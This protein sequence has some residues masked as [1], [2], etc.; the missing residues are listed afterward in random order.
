MFY[1]RKINFNNWQD[2]EKIES[3]PGEAITCCLNCKNNEWSVY[4]LIDKEISKEFKHIIIKIFFDMYQGCQNGINIFFISDEYIK[5]NNLEIKEDSIFEDVQHLNIK[6]VDYIKLNDMANYILDNID[7]NYVFTLEKI[8]EF[9][10][11]EIYFTKKYLNYK[12]R[13]KGILNVFRRH[14]KEQQYIELNDLLK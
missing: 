10:C 11:D 7:I 6:E 9:I 2:K 4:P 12:E 13:K 1:L 14:H 8:W 3:L 5:K